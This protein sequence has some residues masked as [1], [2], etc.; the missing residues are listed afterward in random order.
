MEKSATK[1][2]L[3]QQCKYE[4]IPLGGK[5]S[6]ISQKLIEHI[7]KLKKN[8]KDALKGVYTPEK[9]FKGLTPKEAE[10]RLEEIRK[11]SKTDSSDPNAYKPFTTDFRKGKRIPTKKSEYTQEFEKK[12]G[13]NHTLEQKSKETGIPIDILQQVWD[14]GLAAWRTGHRP[15][16]SQAQWAAARVNSFI[17]KG[18]TYYYPDHLLAKEAKE[19]SEK[20]RKHWDSVKCVCRKGCEI[21]SK[22][23]SK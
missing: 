19:R 1:E 17:M 5:K 4:G 16:A 13:S 15:G 18:C 14:K 8:K 22:T 7:E 11:G 10:K 2:C 3:E 12:F 21:G 6:E 20:A 23:P 9:Y